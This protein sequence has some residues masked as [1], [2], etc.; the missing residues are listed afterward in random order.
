[1]GKKTGTNSSGTGSGGNNGSGGKGV[2]FA[3]GGDDTTPGVTWEPE[4]TAETTTA[5]TVG[6][7]LVIA[8]I[9]DMC[10]FPMDLT[11]VRFIDQQGWTKLIDVREMEKSRIFI[12]LSM[13]EVTKQS[14]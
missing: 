4:A 3:S 13:M 12:R 7:T 2:P 14:Q 9:I 5:A 6:H 1:M 10:D 8:K 11:M